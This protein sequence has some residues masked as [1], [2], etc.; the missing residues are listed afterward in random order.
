MALSESFWEPGPPVWCG[1]CYGS[2]Q[3]EDELP[4]QCDCGH[5]LQ[6]KNIKPISFEH[7]MVGHFG[8]KTQAEI[9]AEEDARVFGMLDQIAEQAHAPS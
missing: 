3:P 1:R 5:L 7:L 4:Q 6:T 9:L 2:S 8:Y